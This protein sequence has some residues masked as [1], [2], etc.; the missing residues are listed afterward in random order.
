MA[1]GSDCDWHL[2]EGSLARTG[3][4]VDSVGALLGCF[5]F[6]KFVSFVASEFPDIVK[7]SPER[8]N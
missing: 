6:V 2:R 4:S 3:S 8:A 1:V 5:A 7:V